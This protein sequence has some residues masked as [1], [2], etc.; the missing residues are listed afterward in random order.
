MSP[1]PRGF[2]YYK[3]AVLLLG[4]AVFVWALIYGGPELKYLPELIVFFLIILL[5][6]LLPI[7][8]PG[9]DSDVTMTVPAV[10]SLLLS[11]GPYAALI[12]GPISIF[13]GGMVV[14]WRRDLKWLISMCSFNTALC[15]LPIAVACLVYQLVGGKTIAQER[16]VALMSMIV[17]L[18]LAVTASTSAN[19]LVFSAGVALNTGDPWRLAFARS[20]RWFMPNYVITAPSGILF[21]YLYKEFSIYGTLLVVLPFIVGRQALNVYS[22]QID[23]YRETITTLGSYMQHYHPYT[24]SHLERVAAMSDRI[25]RH[26][27]LSLPSLMFIRD[28]GLLHDIGK[29]G[30]DE[31]ILDKPGQL[32][33]KD[34]AIIKQHPARGAEILAQMKHLER[35]VSW[36]RSHHERPDGMG[37][38]DGLKA[39]EIPVEA[40]VIAVADAFDAMTGGPDE[41][42]RRGYRAPL[43]LDQAIDQVRYGAG[44]QFDP[45]VVKA[46]MRVMTREETEDGR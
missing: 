7:S 18:F 8:F 20:L 16:E 19:A 38:P 9:T 40:G 39:D 26:M 29:V 28:A 11:H 37:Y 36:V 31:T 45:R 32:T 17:P 3:R 21:A 46:F 2:T 10:M 4:L 42:D 44:I 24:R 13:A 14:H 15:V 25:A 23:A 41:K 1:I 30:V 5:C 6:E 12:V 27:G 43:T 34:W 35:I 22:Q 33:E